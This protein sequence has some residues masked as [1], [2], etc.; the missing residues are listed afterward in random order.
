M[1]EN[2]SHCQQILHYCTKTLQD[3][4]PD[5]VIINCGTNNLGKR[6]HNS[7]DP[8]ITYQCINEIVETCYNHGVNQVF[9]SSVPIRIGQEKKVEE[10]KS[11][12][13][14]E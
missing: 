13:V 10:L 2:G 6:D 1:P 4:Q 12:I 8:H 5:V 11:K 7:N 14:S 3:D 9:V